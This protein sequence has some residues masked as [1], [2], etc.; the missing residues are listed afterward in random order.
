MVQRICYISGAQTV[1]L[2]IQIFLDVT[3]VAGIIRNVEKYSP[4]DTASQPNRL[5]SSI[6]GLVLLLRVKT[7]DGI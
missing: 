5:A 7:P 4:N 3:C 1:L 2:K 6:E